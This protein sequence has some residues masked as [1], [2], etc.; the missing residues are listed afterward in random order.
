[1]ASNSNLNRYQLLAKYFASYYMGRLI[2]MI[3]I[4]DI[5][6]KYTNTVFGEWSFDFSNKR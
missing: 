4:V 3:K 1:M 5:G 2:H 6:S